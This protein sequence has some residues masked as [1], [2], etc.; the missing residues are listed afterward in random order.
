MGTAVERRKDMPGE[1]PAMTPFNRLIAV[2]VLAVCCAGFAHAASVLAH[3][4]GPVN[5]VGSP[6]RLLSIHNVDRDQEPNHSLLLRDE[7]TGLGRKVLDYARHVDVMWAP[8]SKLFFVNDYAGS[9]E[10]NCQIFSADDLKR[11][12]VLETLKGTDRESLPSSD[13]LY[14]AC[15]AWHGDRVGVSLSG[16]GEG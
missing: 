7:K 12:D 13:H 10:S 2:A 4:P 16:R 9:S 3:F 1:M 11:L 8:D 6:N 5:T 15:T 14:V